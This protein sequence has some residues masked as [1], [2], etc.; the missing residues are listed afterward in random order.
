MILVRDVQP[1]IIPMGESLVTLEQ[2][3]YLRGSVVADLAL[4][5]Q[6]TGKP[7]PIETII[8]SEQERVT[9]EFDA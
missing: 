4:Y 6:I 7:S 1:H 2:Y 5:A 9:V 3:R 8:K